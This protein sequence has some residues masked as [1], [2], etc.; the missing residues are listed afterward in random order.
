MINVLDT[1]IEK[2]LLKFVIEKINKKTR[3]HRHAHRTC[4]HNV[5]CDAITVFANDIQ[6]TRHLKYISVLHNLWVVKIRPYNPLALQ[7]TQLL[8]F[9]LHFQ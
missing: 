9:T 2:L 3:Y 4:C 6:L 5:K 7:P 8:F 1:G